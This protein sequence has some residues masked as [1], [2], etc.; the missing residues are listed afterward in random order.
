MPYSFFSKPL[1]AGASLLIS[2]LLATTALAN[3]FWDT[4]KQQA[5]VENRLNITFDLS[6][7]KMAPGGKTNITLPGGQKLNTTFTRLEGHK[8]G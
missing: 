3:D 1:I 7:F 4:D 6:S 2:T 8:L 5:H